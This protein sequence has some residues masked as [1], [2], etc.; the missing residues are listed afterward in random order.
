MT[1]TIR[2]LGRV[3]LCRTTE[4]STSVERQREVVEQWASMHDAQIVGWAIDDGESGSVDPFHTPPLGPWLSD[5][6][7]VGQYD[8]VVAWKL[9]R[10]GRSAVLLS[11]LFGWADDNGKTLVSV[12]ESIDLS[13]RSGRMLA[14]VIAGLAEGELEAIRDSA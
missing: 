6:E 14:S 12:S 4:E 1:G 7:K 8:A 11:K 3:R 9:D 2:V 13:T 10:L 5:P